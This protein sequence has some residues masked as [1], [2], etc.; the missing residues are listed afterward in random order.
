MKVLF[1]IY[2]SIDTL[3]GGYLYDRLLVRA[4]EERGHEVRIFSQKRYGGYLASVWGNFDPA[5]VREARSFAPDIVLE[6]E[7]N[8]SSL[9]LLNRRLRPVLGVPIIGMVHHLRQV[10]RNG[11]PDALVAR[12]L[13]RL[14]LAGLDAYLCNSDFTRTSL[15]RALGKKPGTALPKPSVVARPG[16][17]RLETPGVPASM[18]ESNPADDTLPEAGLRILFL[19]NVIPRKGVHVLLA[20]LGKLASMR[21]DLPACRLTIAG[22]EQ[23]DPGYTR[24][25]V[26]MIRS[27]YLTGRV[28]WSGAVS[29]GALDAIF[30]AHDIL[31]VP[32]Q[33]EGYGIVYAEAMCRGLPVVAGSYGGAAEIIH[34]GEDG[35][36]LDWNDSTGLAMILSRLAEDPA[37]LAKM[38]EAALRRSTGL[39]GWDESMTTAAVF[40]ESISL[41][42]G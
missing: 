3:S 29:D 10:E 12:W 26:R 9:F 7:L 19:G 6:D 14:F 40:L 42:A 33:C 34:P 18:R 39:A 4:L 16:K 17:D 8:H 1:I 30:Q 13:E 36:L 37:L 2:G 11:F 5:A 20:A 22:N 27:K 24:R 35:Y 25:L 15:L 41:S 21:P 32:S 28:V 23:A 31:A 38:K